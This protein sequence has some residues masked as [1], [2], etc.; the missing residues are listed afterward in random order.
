MKQTGQSEND[1]GFPKPETLECFD[2]R[3]K[4]RT[5]GLYVPN[6]ASHFLFLTILY[7]IRLSKA[8]YLGV[9]VYLDGYYDT[10][11]LLDKWEEIQ[12]A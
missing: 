2:R 12:S 8:I 7:Q 1:Q 9:L 3:D 5:C 11:N 10:R 6:I 4:I